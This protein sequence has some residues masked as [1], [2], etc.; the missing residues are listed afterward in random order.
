MRTLGMVDEVKYAKALV[1]NGL[2]K[3]YKAALKEARRFNAKA[4]QG[5]VEPLP[6]YPDPDYEESVEDLGNGHKVITCHV[7][8]K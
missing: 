5:L 3:T 2:F 8:N 6:C 4:E 7:P 1:K